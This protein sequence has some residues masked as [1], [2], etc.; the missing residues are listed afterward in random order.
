V[1]QLILTVIGPDR[2]GLVSALSER[3]AALGGNWLESRLA[4]LAGQ[5]A[6]I[7]LVD[8]PDDAETALRNSLAELAAE[9][10]RVTT[11]LAGRASPWARRVHVKLVTQ[12]R[13]GII[14]DVATAL[15]VHKANIEEM[16]THVGSGPFSGETMFE[17][18]LQL[19]LPADT[20]FSNLRGALERLGN[21]LMADI[22][23]DAEIKE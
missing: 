4:H 20:D 3:V 1:A 17:A 12:D 16:T 22:V 8:V 23:V 6:G 5:F 10:L 7:V 14:R 15:A 11:E 21:E 2:P 18:T 13:P 19:K 9:K